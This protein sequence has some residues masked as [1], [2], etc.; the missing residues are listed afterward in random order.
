MNIYL[1]LDRDSSSD[2]TDQRQCQVDFS[3]T[4]TSI[5]CIPSFKVSHISVL[6][7]RTRK[8]VPPTSVPMLRIRP[9]LCSAWWTISSCVI[10]SS[11]CNAS[12]WRDIEGQERSV[13][14]VVD[15]HQFVLDTRA[16]LPFTK[17]VATRMTAVIVQRI[18]HV[19]HGKKPVNTCAL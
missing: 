15:T 13:G 2:N 12:S 1:F 10:G 18:L 5:S 3:K 19:T 6:S 17:S 16:H 14:I 4:I 8:S 9:S 11:S 7:E